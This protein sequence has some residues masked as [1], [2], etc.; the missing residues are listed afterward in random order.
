MSSIENRNDLNDKM[1]GLEFETTFKLTLE[2]KSNGNRCKEGK[3]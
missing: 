2:T 1:F 3:R